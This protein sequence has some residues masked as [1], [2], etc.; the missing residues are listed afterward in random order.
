[1]TMEPTL[2]LDVGG[3]LMDRANDQTDT[4]FFSDNYLKTTPTAGMF[5]AVTALVARFKGRAHIVSKCGKRVQARTLDWLGHHRF[6]ERTGLPR[7]NV[8]FCPDRKGKA[9]ICAR[10]GISHFVDDKLEVLSYLATVP[11]Q[12]LFSPSDDEIARYANHYPRVKRVENWQQLLA[13]IN[14]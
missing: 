3:V 1:M 10:L 5:E 13:A 7:G 11:R 8:H 12:Y 2:G 6:Y 14:V 9:P 4:S